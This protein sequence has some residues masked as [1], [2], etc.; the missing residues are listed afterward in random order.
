MVYSS[1]R[2]FRRHL[3]LLRM[4]IVA[5][6]AMLF[7]SLREQIGLYALVGYACTC[8]LIDW[9]MERWLVIPSAILHMEFGK[10]NKPHHDNP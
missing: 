5:I 9:Y 2:Y 3:Q 7:Y 8:L 1:F 4:I 10:Q 6:F